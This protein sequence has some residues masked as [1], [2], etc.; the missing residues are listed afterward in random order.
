M[1]TLKLLAIGILFTVSS[2]MYSQV[3]VNVNIGARPV[4]AP[5]AGY[6]A[7][8][9]YYIPDV[10]A[11]YDTRASVFIYL[12]G[13]NWVRARNLPAHYRHYDLRNCHKVALKG[14]RG[15]QP[16]RHFDNHKHHYKSNKGYKKHKH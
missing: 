9:F 1:K 11:Y 8:D 4:W 7:V 15:N 5:A 12:N 16:Y 14:Y 6:S 13:N 2:S 3:S 10:H